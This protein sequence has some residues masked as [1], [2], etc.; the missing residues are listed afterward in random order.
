MLQRAVRT[1]VASALALAAVAG[2]SPTAPATPG[3]DDV[4][5]ERRAALERGERDRFDAFL[6]A[7]GDRLDELGLARPT[8]QGLVPL[9]ERS[10]V[11]TACI[12]SFNPQLQVSRLEGGYTVNYFGVVGETHERIRWTIESCNAQFGTLDLGAREGAPGPL[13]ARWRLHDTAARLEPCLRELGASTQDPSL[14]SA[15][16][17]ARVRALCPSSDVLIEQHALEAGGR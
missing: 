11:V 4:I 1:T 13:E 3:L 7:S 6:A 14:L 5:A 16:L 12:E 2:C 15:S 17:A 8:F 9:E 10:E